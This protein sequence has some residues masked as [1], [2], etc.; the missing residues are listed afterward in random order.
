MAASPKLA[1]M[2]RDGALRAP[3][4][5]EAERAGTRYLRE[6]AASHRRA[7]LHQLVDDRV[8]QRLERGIDDI[9]RY[10]DRGPALAALV[11]A[12]DQHPGHRLRAGVEDTHAVIGEL[13]AADVALVLAEVLAQRHVERMDRAA[14]L[15][16]R[17]QRLVADLDLHHRH[18]DGDALAERV[19]A[20]LDID[21]ELHHVEIA[22]DLAERTPRQQI[23]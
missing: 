11:L 9:G 16:R 23:E 3:P 18:R 7:S 17:D 5:H 22:R 21:V 10:P 14:A 13:E 2:V 8:H 20:L 12:F 15:T 1:A 6:R 19:V 4:H